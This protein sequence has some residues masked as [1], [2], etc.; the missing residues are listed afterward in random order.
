MSEPTLEEW[1]ELYDAARMFKE[2]APWEWMEDSD[3]FGVEDSETGEIGYCCVIGTLGEVLGLIVYR[4]SEG[5]ALIERMQS[6]AIPADGEDFQSMQRCL[7]LTFDDREMLEKRDFEVI[8]RLGLKFRGRQA[9]PS[10]R[11]YS[12]G[13]VP[14]FLSGAEARFLN[15]ATRQ[16]M[17][18]AERMREEPA[19]LNA[20]KKGHYLILRPE[21]GGEGKWVETWLK[22]QRYE[23]QKVTASADELR[24]ARIRAASRRIEDI[25]E[26]D[27]FFAPF[28]IEEG[29]R[30]F[31][32][33][34]ALWA[35]RQVGQILAFS[36]AS[37]HQFQKE[38][39]EA[40]LGI[41][42]KMK[43]LPKTITVR[44]DAV[45][46]FFKPLADE[47]AISLKKVKNLKCL[48]EARGF[49]ENQMGR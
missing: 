47:L 25:W 15:L 16:A 39:Q 44:K 37:Y 21:K 2:L 1:K 14:W 9:W 46:D 24:C 18:V 3:I 31:Y 6:E 30:P 41:P 33:Y 27:F 45:Y 23:K 8:K 49:L 11:S 17:G 42:E 43:V 7:S 35:S 40:F 22:P 28:V 36:L 20:A 48:D 34:V 5:L 19:L 32:P 29:P 12:P 10:C 26:V 13:F 38:F 4:G